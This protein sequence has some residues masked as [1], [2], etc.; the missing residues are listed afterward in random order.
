MNECV[1]VDVPKSDDVGYVFTILLVC[2][3]IF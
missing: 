1:I 2:L 3:T